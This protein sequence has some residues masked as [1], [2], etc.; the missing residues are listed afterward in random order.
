MCS[1]VI[2]SY[3]VSW[4]S[5]TQPYI[6]KIVFLSHFFY[7]YC[8]DRKEIFKYSVNFSYG[9]DVISLCSFC[10]CH[11]FIFLTQYFLLLTAY[12]TVLLHHDL[13]H[14]KTLQ[15]ELYTL[16]VNTLSFLSA[17]NYISKVWILKHVWTFLCAYLQCESTMLS[18]RKQ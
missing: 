3:L 7:I 8:K 17:I 13:F 2:A 6:F 11:Y 1:L 9:H 4:S 15:W 5:S 14:I 18:E 12:C 16:T 10:C